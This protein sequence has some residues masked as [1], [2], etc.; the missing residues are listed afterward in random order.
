MNVAVFN[1]SHLQLLNFRTSNGG[2]K[3]N[4][5]S[6]FLNEI[7]STIYNLHLLYKYLSLG[8]RTIISI[9][10]NPKDKL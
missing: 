2:K 5:A 9:I 6:F 10:D 8:N 1:S 4:M 7:G 3:K